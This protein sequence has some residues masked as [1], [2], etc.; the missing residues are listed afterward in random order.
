M[1]H[2]AMNVSLA[3]AIKIAVNLDLFR[4]FKKLLFCDL[5]LS[6]DLR[7]VVFHFH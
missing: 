1:G 4:F 7:V 6:S 5:K 3:L 2:E